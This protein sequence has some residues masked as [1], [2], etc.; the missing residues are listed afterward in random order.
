MCVIILLFMT[1]YWVWKFAIEDRDVGVVDYIPFDR[2]FGIELPA[3]TFCFPNPFLRDQMES[4]TPEI[5]SSRYLQ[6]LKGD[7]IDEKL[8]DVDYENVTMNLQ[9]YLRLGTVQLR[10]ETIGRNATFHHKVNFNGY[11]GMNDK[12][13]LYKCFEVSMVG[14]QLNGIRHIWLGYDINRL[15]NDM[16][17]DILVTKVK[18]NHPGQL[19]LISGFYI[20]PLLPSISNTHGYIYNIQDLEI[21]QGR[22]SV[23]RRCTPYSSTNSFD[24]MLR[25][26][27]VKGKDCSA[28]YLQPI[29]GVPKCSTKDSIKRSMYDFQ[30]IDAL[31]L[32]GY[33][34]S[35]CLRYSKMVEKIDLCNKQICG[36]ADGLFM[37]GITYPK[38]VKI[39][40][41]SKDVDIHS[42]IGNI[43]GYVGLFLGIKIDL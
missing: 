6:Y 22:N 21:L 41:Q 15:S 17:L 29:T 36:R 34:P 33:Y 4:H 31:I 42:L 16:G 43:G 14:K 28:P 11:M 10:N 39:I 8:T 30:S 38:Y 18:A 13:K 20:M 5:N 32:S 37:I 9:E 19:S 27:H 23:K 7:V 2:S 35:C 1:S 12:K 26:Q 3:V 40:T 24:D 25:E